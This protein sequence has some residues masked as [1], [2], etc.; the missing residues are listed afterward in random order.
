MDSS[1]QQAMAKW[2]DVPNLYGWLRL[3]CRGRWWLPAGLVEHPGMRAFIGRNYAKDH[4]GCWY[5]QNGP[6]R[7]F[8][9]L[10]C[11]PFVFSYIQGNRSWVSHNGIPVQR[12]QRGWNCGG[13]LVLETD[14][15]FGSVDDRSLS[16]LQD[17]LQEDQG[18]MVLRIP[19]GQRELRLPEKSIKDL[20]AERWIA[21]PRQPEQK[22]FDGTE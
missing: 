1:V 14:M 11:A 17:Y 20:S 4:R 9:A 18:T 16:L 12:I 7:V 22:S 2:P 21:N 19:G 10:E 15:G 8:V 3:D 13:L 5:F 6:Q